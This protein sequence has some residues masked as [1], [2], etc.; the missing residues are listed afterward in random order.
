MTSP[1]PQVVHVLILRICEYSKGKRTFADVGIIK[2]MILR[3]RYYPGL[4]GWALCNHRI[5]MRG[6]QEVKRGEDA[7]KIEEKGSQA[8]ECKWPLK[9]S[10]GKETDYVLELPEE[11]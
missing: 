1:V 2:L 6:R 9:A 3:W 8:E 10:K 5:P 4:S 11:A 7:L